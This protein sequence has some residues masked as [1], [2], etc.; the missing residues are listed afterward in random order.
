MRWNVPL[1]ALAALT[2]LLGACVPPAPPEPTGPAPDPSPTPVP[3][4]QPDPEP[5]PVATVALRVVTYNVESG[6]AEATTTA[7]NIATI[8]G[9]SLWGF[10]ECESQAW[11]DTFAAAADDGGQDFRTILGTTG[12]SD[13]LGIAYDAGVLQ[14]ESYEEL[15]AINL[16]GTARAPLVATFVHLPTDTRFLFMVN[17]LWRTDA[18]ARHE[19][20]ELLNTWAQTVALPVIAVGDYNF[21]WAV[22]G[23]ET[24]HDPGYDNLVAGGVWRW[25]RPEV[26]INT[27]C[28]GDA[29]LDFVFVAG[30]ALDWDASSEILLTGN[31]HCQPSV[32][33][34]DHRPVAATF[35]IPLP[36]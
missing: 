2:V 18:G 35:S 23:G 34:P 13:R 14:L 1:F 28:S 17:H 25:V 9:E 24:D 22:E 11:L 20:A 33:R 12:Y 8:Q 21:D 36:G 32:Q 4:P 10:T 29:I 15:H 3:E 30:G 7:E 6:G 19:Q 27:Q 26:L 16:G 5:E 31:V